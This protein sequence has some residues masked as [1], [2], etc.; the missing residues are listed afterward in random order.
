MKKRECKVEEGKTYC[1]NKKGKWERVSNS[2][3]KALS[4][5]PFKKENGVRRV[6]SNVC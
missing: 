5:K 3:A 2:K 1:K 4:T 6:R